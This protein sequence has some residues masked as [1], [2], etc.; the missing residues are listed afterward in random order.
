MVAL[1]NDLLGGVSE[2]WFIVWTYKMVRLSEHTYTYYFFHLVLH[3]PVKEKNLFTKKW[4]TQ[5]P[6]IF[7]DPAP[8]PSLSL[9]IF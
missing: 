8:C 9:V 2:W 6:M 3:K 1:P 4:Q 5:N 7:Y